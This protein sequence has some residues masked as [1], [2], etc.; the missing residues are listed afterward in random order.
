MDEWLPRAAIY[1]RWNFDESV[2]AMPGGLIAKM[3][4]GKPFH[5]LDASERAQIQPMLDAALEQLAPF[6]EMMTNEILVI[7]NATLELGDDIMDW[8]GA[9]LDNMA[10]HLEQ[11]S[12]L[13]GDRPCV[14][15]FVL[16]G[17]F[18]AHFA[19]DTWPRG[20]IAERQPVMLE[21]AEHLWD[22]QAGD[23][24]W[25][26]DDALPETLSP[27]FSEMGRLFTPYL[28]ANRDALEKGEKDFELD[29]G[30]GQRTFGVNRYREH[31]RLDV[32]DEM[33]A[34]E[35]KLET[36]RAA[37]PAEVLDVYLLPPP[38]EMPSLVGLRNNFPDLK[39]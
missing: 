3:M 13:L 33:L 36:I 23:E 24:T 26:T 7:G 17:A 2:E 4:L 11:H 18:A 19:N 38:A 8:F 39:P 25:L 37:I 29:L 28:R 21:W 12:Y 6:R 27:F 31:C 9:L 30:H 16:S 14:A 22:A 10:A 20:F 1:T 32:R 34:S 5:A 35:P 15:D